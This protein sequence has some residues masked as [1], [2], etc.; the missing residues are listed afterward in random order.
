MKSYT[1]CFGEIVTVVRSQLP[2]DLHPALD[3]V[4]GCGVDADKCKEKLFQSL[5][6][7]GNVLGTW[8]SDNARMLGEAVF[9]ELDKVT[10]QATQAVTAIESM[11]SQVTTEVEKFLDG[12]PAQDFCT[13]TDAGRP[14]FLIVDCGAWDQVKKDFQDPTKISQNFD[15]AVAKLKECIERKYH[16]EGWRTPISGM[17]A[18]LRDGLVQ[19]CRG[20]ALAS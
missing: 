4:Q 5:E 1:D 2:P 16:P 9:A 20:Q 6:S 13:P 17:V 11:G 8:L 18:A 15:A 12:I 19:A 3:V 7:L 14:D 10:A